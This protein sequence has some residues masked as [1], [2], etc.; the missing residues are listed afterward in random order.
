MTLHLGC[1]DLW[2]QGS[3]GF[4]DV[5]AVG[6]GVGDDDLAAEVGEELR[7]YGGGGSAFAAR[8]DLDSRGSAYCVSAGWAG[9]GFAAGRDCA[10]GSVGDRPGDG[11]RAAVDEFAFGFRC[12]GF[13]CVSGRAR[14]CIRTRAG[15][16]GFGAGG[17]SGAVSGRPQRLYISSEGWGLGMESLS[18]ISCQL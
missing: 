12:S 14:G 5:A 6:A 17:F 4:V 1:D 7:G 9:A 8:A 3:A 2:M 11:G 15:P 16:I 13:R 18:S 10:Q